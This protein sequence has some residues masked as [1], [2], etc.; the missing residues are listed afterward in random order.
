ML[1][2]F[3]SRANVGSRSGEGKAGEVGG[4]Q[5]ESEAHFSPRPGVRIYVVKREEGSQ[6]RQSTVSQRPPRQG[7][8]FVPST[9][10]EGFQ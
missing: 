3:W 1:S 8:H 6:S 9:W 7:L 2:P 10:G 5:G 4:V